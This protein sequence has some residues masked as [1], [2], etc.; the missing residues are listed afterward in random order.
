MTLQIA[1]A[2]FVVFFAQNAVNGFLPQRAVV[3][4]KSAA[5]SL[6]GVEYFHRFTQD[7][8]HEYTPNGQGDL[9]AWTDMVTIHFYRNALTANVPKRA[10]VQE[11]G[12]ADATPKLCA[13]IAIPGVPNAWLNSSR[14][15][16][17]Q[18]RALFK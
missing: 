13:A 16:A 6:T 18:L 3:K 4:E 11:S 1:F 12:V 2:C 14:R 9:K 5:F 15:Y 7:D 17:A 8:Q 10:R